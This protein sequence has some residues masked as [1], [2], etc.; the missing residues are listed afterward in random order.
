MV[1][2]RAARMNQ[3]LGRWER[4]GSARV[5]SGSGKGRGPGLTR[6][7]LQRARR[8]A[9]TGSTAL[10]QRMRTTRTTCIRAV[11]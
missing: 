4:L 5:E 3:V 8:A 10:R 1:R 2:M 9:A 7:C 6:L 11:A